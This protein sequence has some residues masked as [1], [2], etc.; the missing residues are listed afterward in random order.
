MGFF[1]RDYRLDLSC[2][3]SLFFDLQTKRLLHPVWLT[4]C[5]SSTFFFHDLLNVAELNSLFTLVISKIETWT[6]SISTKHFPSYT[7]YRPWKQIYLRISSKSYLERKTGTISLFC[8]KSKYIDLKTSFSYSFFWQT[9][10]QRI[11][12][13]QKNTSHSNGTWNTSKKTSF[14]TCTG[15]ST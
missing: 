3:D 10:M 13:V 1:Y 8:H 2:L 11:V 6:L 12:S 4:T 15:L 9:G 5:K 14:Y 7:N